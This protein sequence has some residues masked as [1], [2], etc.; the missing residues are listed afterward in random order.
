MT[1]LLFR[2]FRRDED[3]LSLTEGVIVLPVV[4]IVI[5]IFMEFGFAMYQWNRPRRRCSWG[6]VC[7]R[8]R[9]R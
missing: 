1:R 7:W 5:T 9:I 3:G 4:L 8:S 6:R 2:R